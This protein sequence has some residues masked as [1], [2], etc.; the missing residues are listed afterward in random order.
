MS[1]RQF[2][3]Y[4]LTD[5]DSAH[6]YI[7][8]YEALFTPIRKKAKKM[9]EIGIGNFHEKNGGS[10]KLWINYFNKIKIHSLDILGP[11]RVVDELKNNPRIKFYLNKNAYDPEFHK[12]NFLKPK[13]IKFD[14]LID[15]GPHTLDSMISFLNLYQKNMKKKGIL[16]IEDIQDFDWI[17]ILK[18]HVSKKNQKYIQIYDLRNIKNQY[19]DILFVINRN[20][21]KK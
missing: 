3:D 9:L 5:K 21:K 1:L 7:D 17:N 11:E 14:I 16:V 18:N 15:D 20:Q 19:D 6:S 13:K 2:V 8:S 12:N 10:L 4:S